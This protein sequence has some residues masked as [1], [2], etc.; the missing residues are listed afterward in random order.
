MGALRD[1]YDRLFGVGNI[2]QPSTGGISVSGVISVPTG[3]EV[4]PSGVSHTT[5]GGPKFFNSVEDL[6]ACP[7]N[8]LQLD[9]IVTVEGTPRVRYSLIKLPPSGTVRLS[10]LGAS[11][12]ILPEYYQEF[13]IEGPQGIQGIKGD[14]GDKGDTGLTGSQGP[15][16]EQGIQGIPGPKGDQGIQ[17]IQGEVGPQ[18]PQGTTQGIS[19]YLHAFGGSRTVS[20]GMGDFTQGNYVDTGDSTSKSLRIHAW[21]SVAST[22]NW[23]NLKLTSDTVA[24]YNGVN[25]I[26]QRNYHTTAIDSIQQYQ[27]DAYITTTDRYIGFTFSDALNDGASYL[28]YG[29]EVFVLS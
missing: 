2:S 16:G 8:W 26:V 20:A 21:V 18:G 25:L 7:V 12:V 29:I 5:V 27:I 28:D 9:N 19:K 17:G 23:T 6:L 24:G 14:K 11:E 4:F 22:R 1:L 13:T 3:S 15:V 10:D